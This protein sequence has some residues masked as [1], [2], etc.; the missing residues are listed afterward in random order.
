MSLTDE[1][2]DRDLLTLIASG[3]KSAFRELFCRYQNKVFSAAWKFTHSRDAAEDL[4]QEIFTKIWVHKDKLQEV[5]NLSAYIH[6]VTKNHVFNHLR[7][8]ANE[9]KMKTKLTVAE[10]DTCTQV[11]DF[12]QYRELQQLVMEAVSKLP[13]QQQKVYQFSRNQGLKHEEIAAQMGISKST[14]KGHLV[15]AL[16]SIR[17][18]LNSKGEMISA[19]ALIFLTE[20]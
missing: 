20:V 10:P 5:Q 18:Y 8:L 13:P 4:V 2:M 14:V 9:H 11:Y 12:V 3:D 7:K 1:N 19:V 16:G 6:T 17:R 15:E